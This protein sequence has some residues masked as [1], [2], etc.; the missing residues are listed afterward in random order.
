MIYKLKDDLEIQQ[1]SNGSYAWKSATGYKNMNKE[2][3]FKHSLD[4]RMAALE[5]TH[6]VLNRRSFQVMS[7][8]P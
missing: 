7:F 8:E 4:E 6:P 2:S 3:L 1:Y 5:K